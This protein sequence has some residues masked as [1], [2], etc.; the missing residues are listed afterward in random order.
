MYDIAIIGAGVIGSG[1]ARELSRYKLN[2]ALI[3]KSNDVA[4][5]TSKANSAIVHA[6]YDAKF[7]TNKGKF[8]VAGNKIYG[9]ICDELNVPFDRI[10]SYVIGFDDEDMKTLQELYDNGVKLGIEGMEIHNREQVLA[11]EPNI[12]KEVLGGLYAPTAGIVE[13]WELAIAYA[14]NAIDNGTELI[15]NYEVKDINKEKDFF[16]LTNGEDEIEAKIVINAAGVFADKINNMVASPYF[17][18][19]PRKGEYFLLD[20]TS[21]GLVNHVIFQCP[22]KMG[23]GVL[24]TPTIDGNILLGPTSEDID[25]KTDKAT[26]K[27]GL[28]YIRETAL[29][30][31]RSIEFREVI[32]T[33]AGLRAEPSTHDFIIEKSP[34]VDGLINVAGIKSPGLSSAPAIAKEVVTFVDDLMGSL[35]EDPTFNPNR[36]ARTFFNELSKEEKDALIKEDP[37]YGH[38]V[39]RC[40]TITEAEIVDAINRS[41][42]GR[43]INGIKRRCRPGAGRCQGGFCGPRVIEILAREL[44]VDPKE[45]ALEELGSEILTGETKEDC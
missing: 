13:T 29:K 33:F 2:V 20:K 24:V 6:G 31:T 30:T 39:C 42:G 27:H 22:T 17:E 35:E 21:K 37:K 34:E 36:K 16:V 14:E 7:G 5:G 38:V 4:T 3:E 25:D 18:I 12:N 10:G 9:E 43:T 8:N 23:K 19:N 15:L 41:A 26:T 45:I 28:D 1:I 40:E 11:N 32:T 44:D